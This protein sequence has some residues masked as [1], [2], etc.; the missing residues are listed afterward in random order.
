MGLGKTV[1]AI[2]L[3]MGTASH[4]RVPDPAI[5]GGGATAAAAAGLHPGG[6][7]IVVPKILLG[8]WVAELL[9]KCGNLKMVICEFTGEQIGQ[10]YQHRLQA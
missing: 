5:A 2:L 3:M 7:L 1:Q 10:C 8:Q 6:S 4:A 9:H